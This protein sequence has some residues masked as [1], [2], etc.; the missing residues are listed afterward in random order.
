MSAWTRKVE[1]ADKLFEAA[2]RAAVEGRFEDALS[3]ALRALCHEA[4]ASHGELSWRG[5]VEHD[6]SL[7][8]GTRPSTPATTIALHVGGIERGRARVWTSD[9]APVDLF[10][11][12]ERLAWPLYCAELTHAGG[13]QLAWRGAISTAV[14]EVAEALA[15]D[16]PGTALMLAARRLVDAPGVALFS[17]EG[18]EH[19]GL[20]R[21]DDFEPDTLIPEP[22]HDLADGETW[23][24]TLRVRPLVKQGYRDGLAVCIGDGSARR[25]LLLLGADGDFGPDEE[26]ALAEFV[27]PA[28]ALLDGLSRADGLPRLVDP[29][30]G[31]PDQ[32]YF[33]ERLEQE[34]ARAERHLR[35]VSVLVAA[36]DSSGFGQLPSDLWA[37][38]ELAASEVRS[39][40][41]P[42]RVGTDQIG[43]IL[44]DVETMD[45]VLIADRLR[46]TVRSSEAMSG[47]TT[48]SVGSATF[49]ARAGS[50]TELREAATR[51]LGWA[52]TSGVDR[53]FVY[54]R[55]IAAAM[56][57]EGGSERERGAAI[58]DS[59]RLLAD[60][61]DGRRGASGHAT[62]VARISREISRK[63]G[64]PADRSERVYVAALLHDIGQIS[65][66]DDVLG[67]SDELDLNDLDELREHPDIGSRL[68]AGTP[69]SDLR[70]WI[71]HHHERV[72]GT[73]YPDRLSEERIPLEAQIISV[74]EAFEELTGDRPYRA[75]V[76]VTDA[77][78]E[79]RRCAG[80][81]FSESVVDALGSLVEEDEL[82][83]P[84]SDREARR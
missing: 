13:Q 41:V 7:S 55:E 78:A 29:E 68:L 25:M 14:T 16:P 57:V 34:T 44:P 27:G 39:S 9:G 43:I 66:D 37:L 79:I 59:L 32:H 60:A 2:D 80:S 73:G 54:E 49:P 40:D 63:M 5:L 18:L 69:F 1:S 4:A 15:T 72:D 51:A 67:S 10:D 22:L 12:A 52:R 74:A 45:A 75:G 28:Q 46:A 48:L 24:G 61:V 23:R 26:A 82:N 76:T 58:A 21:I 50:S 11:V 47:P 83:P 6:L 77:L 3:A 71:R 20:Y 53:T 56:D 62:R 17:E 19:N 33:V 64:L 8:E 31:L 42:C 35:S 81:Q 38:A 65:M 36:L 84:Y 30:T 70:E